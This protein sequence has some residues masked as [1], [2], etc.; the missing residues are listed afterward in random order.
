MMRYMNRIYVLGLVALA[1]G[2]TACSD[3]D[4]LEPNAAKSTRMIPI[5]IGTRDAGMTTRASD[6]VVGTDAERT[7]H[8]VQL[9]AFEHGTAET[10]EAIAY[11]D[12]TF[13]N[14]NVGSCTFYLPVDDNMLANRTKLDFYVVVNPESAGLTALPRSTAA[15]RASLTSTMFGREGSSDYFGLTDAIHNVPENGLPMSGIYQG[16]DNNGY[17]ISTD[18]KTFAETK[19]NI[20]VERAISKIRFFFSRSTEAT[21]VTVKRIVINTVDNASANSLPLKQFIFPATAAQYDQ[22]TNVETASLTFQN[23]RVA[24]NPLFYSYEAVEGGTFIPTCDDPEIYIKGKV[25][26]DD[27][28]QS[29]YDRIEAALTANK[30]CEDHSAGSWCTYLRES[31][32]QLSGTIYY[33]V[34]GEDKVA[35]FQANTPEDFSR[36]HIYMVYGYFNRGEL[37]LT[38]TVNP[39]EL[40]SFFIEY[41]NTLQVPESGKIKWK[42]GTFNPTFSYPEVQ[43]EIING[44][45]VYPLTLSR[46]VTAECTFEITSPQGFTWTASFN[47][48]SGNPSAFMFVDEEGNLSNTYTGMVG[49][50]PATLRIKAVDTSVESTAQLI[51]VVRQGEGKNIP[52]TEL[53]NWKIVQRAT[54]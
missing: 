4:E 41:S 28:A 38:L 12:T 35:T 3:S 53:S 44:S 25:E 29:Y 30:V 52:V 33:T 10:A 37:R 32:Y 42:D 47:T 18:G 24:S 6:N 51:I 16:A 22:T 46:G 36:N 13:T 8:S 21:N 40:E 43:P 45:T 23:P 19:P 11:K 7:I 54:N 5:S 31:F 39:W 26:G 50:G 2:V 14:N 49:V 48:L 27:D 9:W 34:D 20:I 17:E 15:T 1:F